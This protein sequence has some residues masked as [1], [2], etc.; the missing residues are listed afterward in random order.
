LSNVFGTLGL[1]LVL[2]AFIGTLTG[3]LR[4]AAPAYLI[5]NC[6]GAGILALYSVGLGVWVFVVLEGFWSLVAFSLLARHFISAGKS[7]SNT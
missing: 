5:L 4:T 3:R 2:A 6:V 1:L 7:A